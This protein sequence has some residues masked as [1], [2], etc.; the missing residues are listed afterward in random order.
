MFMIHHV[1]V[2][3]T[4][5][6]SVASWGQTLNTPSRLVLPALATRRSGSTH[7]LVSTTSRVS[8]IMATLSKAATCA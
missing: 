4:S 5:L 2:L 8:V 1:I 3:V 6:L 7:S